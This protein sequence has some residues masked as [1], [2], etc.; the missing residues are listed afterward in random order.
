MSRS[1]SA[2]ASSSRCW[3][4]RSPFE[5]TDLQLQQGFWTKG[6]AVG[7]PVTC[8]RRSPC[9]AG[10]AH[11]GR[12]D[13]AWGG[14]RPPEGDAAA[15]GESEIK[16]A[17]SNCA[18]VPQ[19]GTR[20]GPGK[21]VGLSS[22][23]PLGWVPA[24]CP[25]AAALCCA[26]PCRA[27]RACAAVQSLPHLVDPGPLHRRRD[28]QHISRLVPLRDPTATPPPQLCYPIAACIQTKSSWATSPLAS[29]QSVQLHARGGSQRAAAHAI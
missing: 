15:T 10:A 3:S 29:A 20:V 11:A 28:P 22:P 19:S 21:R 18:A 12:S 2:S 16:T 7:H 9:S 25:L 13:S 23:G 5:L 14:I 4:R 17:S 27:L 26:R 24:R 8:S 1:A 6:A